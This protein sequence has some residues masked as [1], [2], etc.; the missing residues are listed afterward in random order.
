MGG[1]SSA[2]E[3]GDDLSDSSLRLWK[4]EDLCK[5]CSALSL[6]DKKRGKESAAV[7][8]TL[9]LLWH[10]GNWPVTFFTLNCK[11]PSEEED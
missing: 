1:G 9:W 11:L 3:L 8:T 4:G 2:H 7:K 5:D 10:G 6:M